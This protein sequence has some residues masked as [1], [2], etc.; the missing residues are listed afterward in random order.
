LRE[1]SRL[2]HNT[3]MKLT[4]PM[5]AYLAA[6]GAQGGRAGKGAAKRRPRAFYVRIRAMVGKSRRKL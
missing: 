1:A 4:K 6:I 3:V 2:P 5:R